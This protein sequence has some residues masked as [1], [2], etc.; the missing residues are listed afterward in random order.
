MGGAKAEPIGT[1]CGRLS[2]LCR[3]LAGAVFGNETLVSLHDLD[4]SCAL[5]ASQ[6]LC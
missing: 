4:M 5:D 6:G 1:T 2:S 3:F